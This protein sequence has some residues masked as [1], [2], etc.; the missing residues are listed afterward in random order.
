MTQLLYDSTITEYDSYVVATAYTTD[1][2]VVTTMNNS[3]GRTLA[4][5][6]N[7]DLEYYRGKYTGNHCCDRFTTNRK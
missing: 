7:D 5:S 6:A 2:T 3:P 4:F 1:D